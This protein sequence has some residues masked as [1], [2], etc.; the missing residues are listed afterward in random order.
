M[1]LAR[2]SPIVNRKVFVQIDLSHFPTENNYMALETV[3]SAQ[4]DLETLTR[5]MAEGREKDPAL[6]RRIQERSEGIRQR[7]LRDTGPLNVAVDLI[8]EGREE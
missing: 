3:H 5:A 1:T 4:A 8:R 7:I 2:L 6:L